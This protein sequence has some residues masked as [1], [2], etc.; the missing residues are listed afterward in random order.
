MLADTCKSKEKRNS[1]GKPHV[2][3]ACNGAQTHCCCAQVSKCRISNE[4]L[5]DWSRQ[6]GSKYHG[7]QAAK[8]SSVGAENFCM[9]DM[10]KLASI[11]SVREDLGSRFVID[12]GIKIAPLIL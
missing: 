12:M 1:P 6:S 11:V 4:V 10:M 9:P 8:P 2:Y 3:R 5:W 7:E